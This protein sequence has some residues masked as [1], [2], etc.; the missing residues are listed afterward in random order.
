MYL[1]PAL[2]RAARPQ[3]FRFQRSAVSLFCSV[4]LWFGIFALAV[5]RAP[6]VE[7]RPQLVK[8][9]NSALSGASSSSPSYFCFNGDLLYFAAADL[10]HGFELWKS[11][12]SP[13]GTVMVKDIRSGAASGGP[14]FL[15]VLGDLVI[16]SANDGIS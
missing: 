6:A 1:N 12:G 13:E 5:V 4:V 9:I 3:S 11:D 2:P 16:F 8:D 7:R 15:T 14:A 10:H